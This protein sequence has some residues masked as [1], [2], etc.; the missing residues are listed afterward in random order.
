MRGK[1]KGVRRLEDYKNKPINKNG[2][3]GRGEM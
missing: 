2:I 3:G 1:T